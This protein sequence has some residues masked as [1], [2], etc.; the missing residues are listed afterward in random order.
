MIQHRKR[1]EMNKRWP[2]LK[3][4]LLITIGPKTSSREFG[5]LRLR[6]YGILISYLAS[7]RQIIRLHPS[8]CLSSGG[9]RISD[10]G[11]HPGLVRTQEPATAPLLPPHSFSSLTVYPA[12]IQAVTPP[13]RALAFLYP[14]PMYLAA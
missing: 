4:L 12:S 3:P 9:T 11:L 2:A 7:R 6:D 13:L 14:I 1:Q 8:A 5:F 10:H